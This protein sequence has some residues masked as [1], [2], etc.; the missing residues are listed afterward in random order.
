LRGGFVR[1]SSDAG[2]ATAEADE[3]CLPAGRQSYQTFMR[4]S[5]IISLSLH[6]FIALSPF[7][8]QA[9]SIELPSAPLDTAFASLSPLGERKA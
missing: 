3:A 9:S 4:L 7:E 1:H 2:G 5:R 6:R 8:L